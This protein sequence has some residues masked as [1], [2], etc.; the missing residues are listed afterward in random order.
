MLF[1]QYNKHTSFFNP[2]DQQHRAFFARKE[3]NPQNAPVMCRLYFSGVLPHT[4]T[5]RVY[6]PFHPHFPSLHVPGCFPPLPRNVVCTS[7]QRYVIVL[8]RR[9]YIH[10]VCSL[11]LGELLAAFLPL[12]REDTSLREKH[13]AS[14]CVGVC[15]C[16]AFFCWC[17]V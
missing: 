17:V 8:S 5:A 3:S 12:R 14:R 13:G 15:L 10:V 6:F 16:R 1:L 4:P 2:S 11:L 9:K 7:Q